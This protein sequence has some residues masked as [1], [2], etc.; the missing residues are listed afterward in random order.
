MIDLK[1]FEGHT[2][3]PW[4]RGGL[5]R[6][7]DGKIREICDVRGWGWLQYLPNGAQQQEANAALAAAAPDLLAEVIR[8]RAEVARLKGGAA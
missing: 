3:G 5:E 6:I 4:K 8:L 2:P 7:Y 1:T